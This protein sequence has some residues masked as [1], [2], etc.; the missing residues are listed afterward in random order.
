MSADHKCFTDLYAGAVASSDKLTAFAG[1]QRDGFLAEDVLAGLGGPNRPRHMHMVRQRVVNGFDLRIGQRLFVRA[2]CFSNP[3]FVG[4]SLS[5]VQIPRRDRHHVRPL[6]LLHRRDYLRNRDLSRAQ[7]GPSH[8]VSHIA[9]VAL[10]GWVPVLDGTRAST[11][12]RCRTPGQALSL[13]PD[14]VAGSRS[15][16]RW[17]ARFCGSADTSEMRCCTC[18]P[19]LA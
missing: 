13:T 12:G 9:S 4:G 3:K 14:A 7:H 15:V 1:A 11:V 17:S 5:F 18:R 8:F 2:E 19:V 10:A 6:A 16:V